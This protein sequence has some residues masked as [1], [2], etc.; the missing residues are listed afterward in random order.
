MRMLWR[1]VRLAIGLVL[2]RVCVCA[3]VRA[4]PACASAGPEKERADARQRATD[5]DGRSRDQLGGLFFRLR[6]DLLRSV[7]RADALQIGPASAIPS[8]N[9]ITGWVQ[10]LIAW[11]SLGSSAIASGGA[12]TS[13]MSTQQPHPVFSEQ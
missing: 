1:S 2:P 10:L 12:S 13:Q 6:T 3:V 5:T 4:P 9:G 11:M 8:S 7:R